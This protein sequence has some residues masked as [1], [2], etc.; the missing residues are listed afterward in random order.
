MTVRPS[1]GRINRLITRQD[2]G[3]GVAFIDSRDD[4]YAEWKKLVTS[5]AISGKQSHDARFVAAIKLS[6]NN[7]H[8]YFRPWLRSLSGHYGYPSAQI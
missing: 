2:F 4:I 6:S 8:R 1:I 3:E 7:A 5:Q